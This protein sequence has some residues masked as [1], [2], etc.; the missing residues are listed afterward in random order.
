MNSKELQKEHLLE[1]YATEEINVILRAVPIFKK[2]INGSFIRRFRH[3]VKEACDK[4]FWA[5]Y[6]ARDKL[7]I[8]A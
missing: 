2:S 5:G 7:K 6:Y 1:N 8:D 4:S 3:E